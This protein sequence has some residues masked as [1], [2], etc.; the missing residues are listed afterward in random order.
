MGERAMHLQEGNGKMKNGEGYAD[1]TAAT[2]IKNACKNAQWNTMTLY[3]G[4][5]VEIVESRGTVGTYVAVA[6]HDAYAVALKLMRTQTPSAPYRIVAREE[7]YT[8][9]GRLTYKTLDSVQ[10]F[11]RSMSADEVK[12][13]KEAVKETLG[14]SEEV[15]SSDEKVK[16]LENRKAEA[17]DRAAELEK[18]VQEMAEELQEMKKAPKEEPKENRQDDLELVKVETQRDMYKGLYEEMLERLVKTA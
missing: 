1:P 3:E 13:L 4:D 6:V 8:D 9:P 2:A 16:D 5:I 18:K 10:T 17:E 14:L 11:I 7:M 15:Q 12:S